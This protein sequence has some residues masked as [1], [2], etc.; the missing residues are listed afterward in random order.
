MPD[1]NLSFYFEV[2][3]TGVACTLLLQQGLCNAACLQSSS[4]IIL[5][6]SGGY[7]SVTEQDNGLCSFISLSFSVALDVSLSL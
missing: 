1:S 4:G 7:V 3:I 6:A 2:V 5:Q